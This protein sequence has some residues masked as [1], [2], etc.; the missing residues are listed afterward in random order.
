[1]KQAGLS[2]SRLSV[3]KQIWE[4]PFPPG[5]VL[6]RSDLQELFILNETASVLWSLLQQD[7]SPSALVESF[8]HIYGLEESQAKGDVTATLSDWDQRL[9]Y[10]PSPPADCDDLAA[11]VKPDEWHAAESYLVNDCLVRI[12]VS[13][14]QLAAEISPRLESVHCSTS[15]EPNLEFQVWARNGR[16]LLSQNDELIYSDE[17]PNAIRAILLQEMVRRTEQG[18]E[19]LAVLHAAACGSENFCVLLAGQSQSGKTTLSAALMASGLPFYCD[20]SAALS[21]DGTISLMPFRMMV[22]EGSWDV[23][24]PY[25]PEITS[26]SVFERFGQKVR[27]LNPLPEQI[28]SSPGHPKALLFISYS[29][30]ERTSLRPLLPFEALLRLQE[31]GF[32]VQHDRSSIKAFLDWLALLPAF[33]FTYSDLEDAVSKIRVLSQ[34]ACSQQ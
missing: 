18:R 7:L 22:R 5:L 9:L 17:N 27:F 32:W 20:D 21:R 28:P 25:F 3:L 15:R 12:Q 11:P 4:F 19:W 31:S 16:I 2:P 10:P 24:Q 30:G 23:L 34:P 14:P 6:A 1:M 26:S 29:P 33:A 13:G 8:R